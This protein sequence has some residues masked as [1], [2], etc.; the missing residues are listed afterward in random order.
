MYFTV[1]A[2]RGFPVVQTKLMTPAL[3]GDTKL[4]VE[5]REGCVVG[6]PMVIGQGVL[7]ER[8]I[9][10]A[11]GSVILDRPL[12]HSHPKGCPIMFYPI[13]DEKKDGEQKP[14]EVTA[15]A[16]SVPTIRTGFIEKATGLSDATTEIPKVNN[17]YLA[18]DERLQSYGSA[19]AVDNL[20][21]FE[22][23][24]GTAF[25][26]SEKMVE[27]NP[28]TVPSSNFTATSYSQV[29]MVAASETNS[30]SVVDRSVPPPPPP[31]A[32]PPAVADS[33]PPASTEPVSATATAAE[34]GTNAMNT[35]AKGTAAAALLPVAM[36]AAPFAMIAQAVKQEPQEGNFTYSL[37]FA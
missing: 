7:S 17:I 21:D 23:V 10:A 6:M 5:T 13:S 37:R 8:A 18:E 15:N 22:P 29:P 20:D 2:P 4:D 19:V 27:T 14:R 11:V 9:I 25:H 12:K 35:M 30:I 16:T 36:V 34:M 32:A 3:K 33:I 24:L 31:R 26:D 28:V 1:P